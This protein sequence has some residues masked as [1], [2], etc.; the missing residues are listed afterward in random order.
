M[1]IFLQQKRTPDVHHHGVSYPLFQ[2]F[3]SISKFDATTIS[4]LV[5]GNRTIV[6][7]KIIKQ[8]CKATQF[9]AAVTAFISCFSTEAHL[10]TTTL[11]CFGDSQYHQIR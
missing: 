5:I 2:F 8:L 6:F 10:Q 4:G 11:L 9:A 7:Y 1:V 3:F